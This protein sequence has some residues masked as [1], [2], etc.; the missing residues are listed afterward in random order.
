M[1]QSQDGWMNHPP[2][3]VQFIARLALV[4][5]WCISTHA[6]ASLVVP[7]IVKL[8][9]NISTSPG[10]EHAVNT[11]EPGLK[12]YEKHAVQ[13]LTSNYVY[14]SFQKTLFVDSPIGT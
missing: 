10:T 3:I 6:P 12:Q 11:A 14:H 1:A 4:I 7:F 8:V 2:P 5:Q 13:S 9:S